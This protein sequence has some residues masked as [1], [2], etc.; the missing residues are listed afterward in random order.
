MPV[1]SFVARLLLSLFFFLCSEI[2]HAMAVGTIHS[3]HFF[4][5]VVVVRLLVAAYTALCVQFMYEI[6]F[7]LIYS[8]SPTT[9]DSRQY[10]IKL[11]LR[12]CAPSPYAA[13]SIPFRS[14]LSVL[15]MR[16][17]CYF[18]KMKTK[19]S[20]RSVSG[21]EAM[22]ISRKEAANGQSGPESPYSHSKRL[23]FWC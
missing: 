2:G 4:A 17:S 1:C 19:S 20:A 14:I 22:E 10:Y 3:L 12:F 11:L 5:F 7:N 9:D 21:T 8:K 18:N 15:Y 16:L 6:H 13:I 23:I